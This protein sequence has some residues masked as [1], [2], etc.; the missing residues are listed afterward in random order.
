MQSEDRVCKSVPMFHTKNYSLLYNTRQ[1]STSIWVTSVQHA[2][3][4]LCKAKFNI[5][6]VGFEVL[7][8]VVTK[9]SIFWDITQCS[10]LK[11]NRRF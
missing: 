1:W 10:P 4:P 9:S 3:C 2:H 8:A 7:M 11:L 6:F 5:N